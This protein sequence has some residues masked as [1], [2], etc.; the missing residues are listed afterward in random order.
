M[1]RPM[2]LAMRD[3]NVAALDGFRDIS[4]FHVA[5]DQALAKLAGLTT[6]EYR[7]RKVMEEASQEAP[8]VNDPF[9]MVRASLAAQGFSEKEVD[10]V[11]TN[12]EAMVPSADHLLVMQKILEL[13]AKANVERSTPRMVPRPKME[14]QPVQDPNDVRNQGRGSRRGD[15]TAAA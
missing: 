2:I 12:A 6:D 3:G 7:R 15:K 1:V 4:G 10:T 8:L 14:R 13:V 5:V 11:I 9:H